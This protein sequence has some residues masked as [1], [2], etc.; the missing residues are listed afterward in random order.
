MRFLGISI[1]NFASFGETAALDFEPG[2]N[3]IVGQNNVGKSALLRVFDPNQLVDDRHRN[4]H[5]F[6]KE[7]LETPIVRYI[8]KISAEELETSILRGGQP[9]AWPI[10]DTQTDSLDPLKSEGKSE[11]TFA[12]F[13]NGGQQFA[14]E[15]S[16]SHREFSGAYSRHLILRP[17]NGR[18]TVEGPKGGPGDTVHVP[19]NDV[20]ANSL[21]SFSAQRFGIGKHGYGRS[22]RL[23]PNALNLAQILAVL[24]GERGGVFAEI[25]DNVREIFPTVGNMSVTTTVG[26]EL[27]IMVWPTE[28]MERKELGFSLDSSGTGVSQVV[29]ILTVM[30]T[31]TQ[32]V[33]VIDEINSFLHPAAT[34]SLLRIAQTQYNKHQ[35]IISTHSPDVIGESNAA[36]VHLVRRAGYE[37][38]VEQVDLSKVDDFRDLADQLGIS[39][40]DVFGAER[41]I[42]V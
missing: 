23:A 20:V 17:V 34:K 25:V 15:V 18:V 42:W 38:S 36:T 29:A 39:M 33:I 6:R 3:L 31:F 35:Y 24:Q 5:S 28:R 40:T 1:K 19:I 12:L 9:I 14:N 41:I 8:V 27:E 4:E 32:A 30:S 16:P 2:I 7:R 26:N 37:S 11:F 22:E 21:F 10:S 13:R